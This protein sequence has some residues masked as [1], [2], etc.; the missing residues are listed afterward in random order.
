LVDALEQR[1]AEEY[2]RAAGGI[3]GLF[4]LDSLALV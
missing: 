2:A 3:A 4:S 1:Q